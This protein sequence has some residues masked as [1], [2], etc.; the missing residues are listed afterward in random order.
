MGSLF[1]S[2]QT[3]GFLGEPAQPDERRQLTVLFYDIVGSTDMLASLDPEEI[4]ETLL[5]VHSIARSGIQANHGSLE[6]VLGDGGMAYFGFPDPMEDAV[7]QAVRAAHGILDARAKLERNGQSMPDVRI[8][9]STSIVILPGNAAAV[10]Q[11]ALGAVGVAPNLAARLQSVAE[12]N[13][14]LVDR[15]THEL[16]RRAF[17]FDQVEGLS[18][19]GFPDVSVAFSLKR[20]K[21]VQSRFEMAR[22]SGT[23]LTSRTE[24]LARLRNAWDK[25]Q[26][27]SGRAIMVLGE[28]GI[29]KSRLS[30]ALKDEVGKSGRILT[31]QN[32]PS[33][34][35]SALYPLITMYER[36]WENREQDQGIAN[37]AVATADLLRGLEK[38]PNISSEE[39]RRRIVQGCAEEIRRLSWERPCLLAV[40]DLHWVDEVTLALLEELARTVRQH[41]LFILVT[42]RNEGV[43][44]DTRAVFED[45]T[46]GPLS[47]GDSHALV[48]AVTEDALSART[49]DWIVSKCDGNPL[50]LI[51]LS[52]FAKQARESGES[53]IDLLNETGVSSLQ[54]LLAVRIE[55][56][57]RAKRSARITSV[58]GRDANYLVLSKLAQTRFPEPELE[59]D[60]H[61]LLRQ[62]I[63]ETPD[64]GGTYVFKHAL[65]REAAYQTQL[66]STRKMLHGKIVDLVENDPAVRARVTREALAEHC[67]G[68]GRIEKGV[69][70]LIETA[71]TAIRR[72]AVTAPEASLQRAL[73]LTAKI[74]DAERRRE[75]RLRIITLLGPLIS[76]VAGPRGAAGIYRS[77]QELVFDLEEGQRG[78]WF[79]VLWGWWFTASDQ[80]EQLR[81]ADVIIKGISESESR[82]ARLQALHCGWATQFAT[83][84]HDRCLAAIDEGLELYDTSVAETSR[85][86]YGHDARVCGLGERAQSLWMKG[87]V[88]GSLAAIKKAEDWADETGHTPSTLHALDMATLAAFYRR[89]FDEIGRT[90]GKITDLT[91]SRELPVIAAKR[92]IFGGWF[93]ARSNLAYDADRVRNGLQSLRDLGALEDTP[94]YADIVAETMT[95]CGK[96]REAVADLDREIE[97]ARQTNLVFWVPELLRRRAWLSTMIG[98]DERAAGFLDEGFEMA[99][100]QNANM[101]LLRNHSMRVQLGLDVPG[102]VSSTLLDRI[103]LVSDGPKKAQALKFL[104]RLNV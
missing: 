41:P 10:R 103:D 53:E 75:T 49:R 43:T 34:T 47:E 55:N 64:N 102:E 92:E 83:G 63:L 66:R 37:A 99:K 54:D 71:E 90:L 8:G 60:L 42:S 79:P 70:L 78:E 20:Q 95:L 7:F 74:R 5:R 76:Q 89:D 50:F 100:H 98:E 87:D 33:T 80:K 11:G 36:A 59:V 65:I 21:D 57:G 25:T 69:D 4:R 39:R 31:L 84:A 68:S 35:G 1:G 48:R 12:Q 104:K 14:V 85:H 18:L 15:A 22:D 32:Q 56:A 81:R 17:E 52:A 29:G 101:L 97:E 27:G 45:M 30:V 86:H 9:I 96:A 91:G 40:E 82:E 23:P 38:D 61:Q 67:L 62:A 51:E 2:E 73:K 88:E 19:K 72:S 28:A 93:A 58:I 24:E 94:I 6:Q 77:G 46:L 13:T 16:T 3:D 26:D 44:A